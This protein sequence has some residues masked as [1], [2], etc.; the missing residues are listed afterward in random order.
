MRA[1]RR[2]LIMDRYTNLKV[3]IRR[4]SS[5]TVARSFDRYSALMSD[6]SGLLTTKNMF[7]H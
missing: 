4:A 1:N 3:R 2:I 6:D 5:K 7:V